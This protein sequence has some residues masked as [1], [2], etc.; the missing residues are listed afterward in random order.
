[1]SDIFLN[2]ARALD[3]L[4]SDAIPVFSTN[5]TWNAGVWDGKKYNII[6]GSLY[7]DRSGDLAIYQGHI[8]GYWDIAQTISVQSG[9]TGIFSI[10]LIGRYVNMTFTGVSGATPT[11]ANFRLG[12]WGKDY[13]TESGNIAKVSGE[14]V[15]AKTS[16]ALDY[17]PTTFTPALTQNLNSDSGG[18]AL[19]SMQAV[20]VMIKA[21]ATNSGDIL[22]GGSGNG[23]YSSYGYVMVPGATEK[24]NI[25]NPNL[26][27]GF[28]VY[29]GYGR[30]S[31]GGLK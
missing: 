24:I 16:G 9:Q 22:L 26:L 31:I 8:S 12:S 18:T 2:R 4:S 30:V 25:T 28:A 13:S 27:Y 7:A 6:E 10:P 19:A 14:T 17:V 29:S 5:A 11:S 3:F 1:M 15:T 20:T 21:L 23:P